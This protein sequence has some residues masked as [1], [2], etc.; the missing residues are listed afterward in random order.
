MKTGSRIFNLVN[1]AQSSLKKNVSLVISSSGPAITKA[2][3]IAEIIKR[4][5]EKVYQWN[6]IGFR[7]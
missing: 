5:Q 3:T 6:K 2:V 1:F 4:K 7:E